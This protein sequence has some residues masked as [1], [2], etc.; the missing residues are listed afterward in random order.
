[1]ST[2]PLV[3]LTAS[4]LLMADLREGQNTLRLIHSV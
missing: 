3:P 1:M 4:V 2:T